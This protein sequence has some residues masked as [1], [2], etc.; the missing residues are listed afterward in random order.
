L[1]PIGEASR[2]LILRTISQLEGTK[3]YSD[4]LLDLLKEESN[5]A[6]SRPSV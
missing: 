1:Q 3:S 6:T 4:V 5:I 2:D